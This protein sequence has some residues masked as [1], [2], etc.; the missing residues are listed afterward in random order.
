[1]YEATG[2]AWDV[3][4]DVTTAVGAG[5]S[6]WGGATQTYAPGTAPAPREQVYAAPEKSG[7]EKALPYVLVGGA[8]LAIIYF[9]TKK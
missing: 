9:A 8:A 7:L 1:M 6:A 4:K 3:F 2:G 5:L